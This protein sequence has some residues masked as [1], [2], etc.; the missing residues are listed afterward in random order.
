[1]PH[2]FL[3]QLSRKPLPIFTTDPRQVAMLR[4]L[5]CAGYVDG[6]LYPQTPEATQFGEVNRIMPLGERVR[7]IFHDVGAHPGLWPPTCEP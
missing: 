3:D 6:R 7:S 5:L 1:M 4:Q 2:R